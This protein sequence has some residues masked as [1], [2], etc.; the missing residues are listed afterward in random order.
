MEIFVAEIVRLVITYSAPK[1]NPISLHLGPP[2]RP[3]GVK[4]ESKSKEHSVTSKLE[5]DF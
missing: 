5:K 2:R 3:V 1:E 4:I